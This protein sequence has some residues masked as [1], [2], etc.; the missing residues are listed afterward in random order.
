MIQDDITV[1]DFSGPS[2]RDRFVIMALTAAKALQLVFAGLGPET[3]C[4]VS[5][6]H[7][8]GFH[9][10]RLDRIDLLLIIKWNRRVF[11]CLNDAAL[12]LNMQGRPEKSAAMPAKFPK[13]NFL[14]LVSSFRP[15]NIYFDYFLLTIEYLRNAI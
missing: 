15:L 1:G 10:K 11:V 14:I 7:L 12:C 8:N 6:G 4:L 5:F 9:R 3:P 2:G 13:D